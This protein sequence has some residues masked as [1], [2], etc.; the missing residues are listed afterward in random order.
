MAPAGCRPES[1][2]LAQYHLGRI[3]R[4]PRL[5]RDERAALLGTVAPLIE[6]AAG[7]TGITTIISA[8]AAWCWTKPKAQLL[9]RPLAG[10]NPDAQMITGC[11]LDGRYTAFAPTG[12]IGYARPEQ[13]SSKP[14]GGWDGFTPRRVV[15]RDET[16]AVSW[17]RKAV[18][19]GDAAS[20]ARLAEMAAQGRASQDARQALVMVS[21]GGRSRAMLRARFNLGL[22]ATG[23]G[24][25]RRNAGGGLVLQGG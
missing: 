1:A 21:Q 24:T 4:R 10:G 20:Q 23:Q 12:V 16:Q 15:E 18:E 7:T 2:P 9:S 22:Y 6:P 5:L 14:S 13:G 3:R 17:Y 8:V 11:Y 19:A 25:A